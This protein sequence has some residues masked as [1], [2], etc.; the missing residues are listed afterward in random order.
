MEHFEAEKLREVDHLKSRFFA[1]ISHEFR[2]PLTLI[3]GPVKQML[4]EEFIGNVKNQYKMIL[5]NSDRLLGLINQI[6]D[7]SKLESGE[8]NL[9]VA[10]T[11]IVQYLKGLVLTFS[12]LAETKKV[13]LKFTSPEKALSG[14]VDRDKLE[15]IITNLLSNALKYTPS[16]GSIDIEI[17]S[18]DN[19]INL[20]VRDN[21]IGI[22]P[23]HVNKIFDRYYQAEQPDLIRMGGSG[24][25]LALTKE[26]VEL[27][28][29]KIKVKSRKDKG[30]EFII[31]IYDSENL[32]I[33]R[34][35]D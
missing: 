25:G 31:K 15:K 11:D 16:G 22:N 8:I 21:G 2:T 17:T 32:F 1:N 34:E 26:L 10:E 5:R 12:P 28:N 20:I 9:Q 18:T 6:L 14:Y 23:K 27:H 35:R 13:T 19:H 3:K 7:L 33:M 4:Q 29:G 30:A 24:I